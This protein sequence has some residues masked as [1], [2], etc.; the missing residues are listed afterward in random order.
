M[1]LDHEQCYRAFESRDRRFDGC[2]VAAVTTTR[3]Y[4]RPSCP[5]VNPKRQNVEFYVTAAAAQQRGFRACKRCRPDATPGSPEWA[6]RADVVARAMRL[7]ADG[8]V[9]R[10]GVGGLAGRLHYSERQMNRLLVGELGAGPLAL[11]RAQRAQT[12]RLLIE[13]TSLPIT[14][15]AFAAGFS[16]VRQFNDTIREVYA[17]TPS[18]LRGARRPAADGQAQI[19]VRLAARQPLS[20]DALFGFLAVR[21]VPGVEAWDGQAYWRS[22]RLERGN[23]VVALGIEGDTIRCRM[24]LDD[25]ADA[26]SA[27][28]RCRR[29]LDLDADPVAIDDLL[30]ADPLLAPL[31]TARPGL[32]SPGHPDGAELLTRA[33]LGQQ[34]T[35]GAARTLAGR[36]VTSIGAPLANPIGPITHVFPAAAAIASLAPADLAM[37]RSRAAAL[38]GANRAIADGELELGPGSDRQATHRQLCALPGIGPWTASYVLMRALNDPD[39]FLPTDIG[40]RNALRAAGRASDPSSASAAAE[41]WRPWRSYALHHLWASL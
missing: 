36:I 19:S 27:V 22:M 39:A 17:T 7:I 1:Q 2:F 18:Q 38:I 40:V 31:V 10:E 23:G 28:Q 5:A 3:I 9:D 32:R 15:I 37:P 30:R 13:T 8:V 29:L 20:A 12:A 26:Q 6:R 25:V 24:W 11:A 34:V 14:D 41:S 4:C 33:V 16:S 21:A 35:V